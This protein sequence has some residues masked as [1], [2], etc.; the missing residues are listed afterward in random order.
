MKSF[1]IEYLANRPDCVSACAAWDYGRWGVQ[2]SNTS[3]ENTIDR[4]TKSTNTGQIPLT[5]VMINTETDCP[6][7]MGSLCEKDGTQ[8]LDKTPWISSIYTLYRYRGLGLAKRIVKSLENEAKEM[9]YSELFLQ[10]GSAAS[11]YRSL[12]Y[13]EVETVKTNA[14]AAG[15]ETL[16]VKT[17][18]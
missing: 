13:Q 11:L 14:T 4:F 16:F 1:K 9:G 7:A 8:W 17:L 5:L 10:S 12:C 6:V 15:T 3:L 2:K 18:I